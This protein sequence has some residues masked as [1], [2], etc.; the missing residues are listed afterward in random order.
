M[1]QPYSRIADAVLDY[2]SWSPNDPQTEVYDDTVW[3]MGE[4]ANLEVSRITDKKV[5][6]APANRVNGDVR[7]AGNIIG[8]GSTY[9]VNHNAD[10]AL[11]TLRFRLK[12]ANVDAAEE[13]FVAAGQKFNRGS[14]IIRKVSADEV[15][16]AAADLGIPVYAFADAPVVQTH[17]LQ[18]ARA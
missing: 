7:T 5:L 8:S 4:L 9:L 18:S 14:F 10:N 1:D 17:A 12:D 16:P 2:Q 15:Q 13:P 6:D 3:T 11:V